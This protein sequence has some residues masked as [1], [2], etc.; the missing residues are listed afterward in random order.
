MDATEEFDKKY[1][2]IK[3]VAVL[4]GVP[5]STLRYWEQEFPEI[6][7]RRSRTNLRYYT[8]ED[9]KILQMISY[10]VKVKGLRIEAAK[11]EL[12]NNKGN[13]SRRLE[14]IEMLT[15]TRD[16]LKEILSALNKRK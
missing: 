2:K 4:L 3:D 6:K 14:I 10:L 11:E 12:R 8:P 9:I 15:D 5:A 16:R 7:P 1:Y 13:V